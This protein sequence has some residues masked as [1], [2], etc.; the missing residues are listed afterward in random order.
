MPAV[1][2]LDFVSS[3]NRAP[4]PLQIVATREVRPSNN[5]ATAGLAIERLCPLVLKTRRSVMRAFVRT[6]AAASIAAL[7][8]SFAASA[9]A[10]G[11]TWHSGWRGAGIGWGAA[12]AVSGAAIA[13]A[14][15]AYGAG[16]YSSYE[17]GNFDGDYGANYYAFPG[18]PSRPLYDE[19]GNV[20]GTASA[21]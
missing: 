2:P 9:F 17:Y 3:R 6:A 10:G 13:S 19:W 14:P 16:P 15:Y 4:N 11:G 8:M 21:C 7:V 1:A 20:I 12:G 5:R 18:C